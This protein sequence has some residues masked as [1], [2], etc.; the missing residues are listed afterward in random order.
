MC[1][2]RRRRRQS[3]WNF[4]RLFSP[5]HGLFLSCTLR[6]IPRLVPPLGN[7]FL[8]GCRFLFCYLYSLELMTLY[9]VTTRGGKERERE[10]QHMKDIASQFL[11]FRFLSVCRLTITAQS[12]YLKVNAHTSYITH[13]TCNDDIESKSPA[14]FFIIHMQTTIK[15]KLRIEEILRYRMEDDC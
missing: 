15:Y 2:R 11:S 6:D 3:A 5:P 13:T 4:L 14:K 10:K 7:C 8:L 12:P 1:S 9:N